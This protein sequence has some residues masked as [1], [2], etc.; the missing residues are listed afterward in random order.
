MEI[1][2]NEAQER[3][4]L[5]LVP[6]SIA[7]FAALCERERC[8]FAVVGEITADGRLVVSDPQLPGTPVDMPI[9][10]LLGKAPRMTRDVRSTPKSSSA[11]ATATSTVADSLED[12][13]STRLNSSPVSISYAVF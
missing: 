7:Q 6:G 2:C 3:Y 8:P 9:E 10:V 5:A 12:R 11:L 13:K 1:W 4:V